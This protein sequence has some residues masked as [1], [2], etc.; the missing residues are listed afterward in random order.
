MF[1]KLFSFIF[2]LSKSFA[3]NLELSPRTPSSPISW[4]AKV[5]NVSSNSTHVT[6]VKFSCSGTWCIN[7]KVQEIYFRTNC[8]T[9]TQIPKGLQA[10]FPNLVVLAFSGCFINN[11]RNDDL[12]EYRG[13]NTFYLQGTLV[14]RIPSNFFQYTP[15]LTTINLSDNVI[16]YVEIGAFNN[17]GK[18]A[19]LNFD[20]NICYNSNSSR[21]SG[22]ITGLISEI[23]EKC[24]DNKFKGSSTSPSPLPINPCNFAI[25]LEARI[26]KIENVLKEIAGKIMENL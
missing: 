26:C 5:I 24:A 19:T 25:I 13:L 9:L 1:L 3:I 22:N 7:E 2:L 8:S 4:D 18:L 16:K 11:L 6:G 20:K 17:L 15:R 21:F 23:Y 14:E 10:F 12:M